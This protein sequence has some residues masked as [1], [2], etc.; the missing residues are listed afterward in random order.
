MSG[1]ESWLKHASRCL[2]ASS[3]ALVRGEIQEHYECA[4]E[5]ALSAG[6]SADEAD[7][8]A[9]NALGD[10]GAAN[11][12]YRR[13]LL[14]SGEARLLRQGNWEARA[15]CSGRWLRWLLPTVSAAAVFAAVAL[16]LSG[17]VALA[18]TLL[19]GGTAIGLLAA[20][21]FLPVYTPARGRV[22]RCVKWAALLA[23]L[24]L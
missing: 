19:A 3:V 7:R 24:V 18:G 5:A 21:R 16:F 8:L 14:T 4:R 10:A 11:R 20:A 17:A 9:E 12:Q 13:V 1:L 22:F 15:V 2:S 23:L 6:A